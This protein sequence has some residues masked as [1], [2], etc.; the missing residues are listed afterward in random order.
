MAIS[1]YL[2]EVCGE[3]ETFKVRSVVC[4]PGALS[5]STDEF[6]TP[7]SEKMRRWHL[8]FISI[9]P[10]KKRRP[11]PIRGRQNLKEFTVNFFSRK[12]QKLQIHTSECLK[13]FHAVV[14]WSYRHTGTITMRVGPSMWIS[15]P[16]IS[17]Y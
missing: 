4:S 12:K 11:E 6:G 2:T 1:I 10:V 7:V 5:S 17:S 15:V 14:S 8:N 16:V 3:M 13:T 9:L